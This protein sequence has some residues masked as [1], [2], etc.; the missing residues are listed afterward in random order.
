MKMF[1]YLL[2]MALFCSVI[3]A[4]QSVEEMMKQMQQQVNSEIKK[5]EEAVQ[6]FIS[7]NDS[8][9]AEF[10][11]NEWKAFE[12][13][14]AKKAEI[15]PKPTEIPEIPETK[16]DY[17][18]YV[19]VDVDLPELEIDTRIDPEIVP[20]KVPIPKGKGYEGITISFFKQKLKFQY[21]PKTKIKVRK[22]VKD[23][24]IQKYFDEMSHVETE[25]MLKQINEYSDLFKL[26]D[27]GKY[28]LVKSISKEILDDDD[29]RIVFCWYLMT[30]LGFDVRIGFSNSF[31]A[32]MIPSNN[33][34]F[35][36][37]YLTINKQKFFIF[38]FDDTKKRSFNQL[39]TYDKNHP[40]ASKYFDFSI[41]EL[42][43]LG[44][45]NEQKNLNFK[46]QG[47][48]YSIKYNYNEDLVKFFDYYPQTDYP[49][50]FNA[51]VSS[52]TL[53]SFI[54]S[55]KP[56]IEKKSE[57][58]ALNI[59]LRF[60]QTAFEYKTDD[61]NFGRE[62]PLIP[63][64]T[65]Y[66]K[67]SDCED[68]SIMFAMLVKEMLG[69]KVVGLKYTGHMAVGVKTNSKPKGDYV[70]SGSAKYLVCDPTYINANIGQ[71]MPQYKNKSMKVIDF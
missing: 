11:K 33:M 41:K 25:P 64:E 43:V 52:K 8:L 60:V 3:F 38:T 32:L 42:P 44:N 66:Y 29:S 67:Y 47:K 17:E 24:A 16:I 45:F 69:L 55:F 5:N 12:P 2:I 50:Y 48:V 70:R 22:P 56:I 53:Y 63:D 10:L 54:K 40:T 27:Y 23:K 35:G 14:K 34:L 15:K 62:K 1:K 13:E 19:I 9:F 58:E 30:K 20:R 7:K 26:N 21:N 51:P 61:D 6:N 39:Y 18:E 49:I 31:T 36:K 37:P 4:Q 65:F 46:Y 28:L 59:I 68:R 57:Q 71:S